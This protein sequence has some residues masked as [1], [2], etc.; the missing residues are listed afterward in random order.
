MD[1]VKNDNLAENVIKIDN[2]AIKE[3]LGI[4]KIDRYI[5]QTRNW[6]E[7]LK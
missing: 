2:H 7:L 3:K 1:Y 6:S 5:I 4:N